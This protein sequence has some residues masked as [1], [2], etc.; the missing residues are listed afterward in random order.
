MHAAMNLLIVL[1]KN[2]NIYTI[3][4]LIRLLAKPN[5]NLKKKNLTGSGTFC[6]EIPIDILH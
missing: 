3:P 5:N 6:F 2:K 4:N 1:E